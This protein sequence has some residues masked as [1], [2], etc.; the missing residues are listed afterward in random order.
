M[1][2]VH[3]DFVVV[4]SSSTGSS[5]TKFLALSA[6]WRPLLVKGCLRQLHVKVKR[7][8]CAQLVQRL[9]ADGPNIFAQQGHQMVCEALVDVQG[10]RMQ[11]IWPRGQIKTG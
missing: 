1:S 3:F 2:V 4:P 8:L 10:I 5:L 6:V 9:L 7:H 11:E